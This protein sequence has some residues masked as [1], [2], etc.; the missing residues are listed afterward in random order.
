MKRGDSP[1]RFEAPP[2]RSELAGP[3]WS[4]LDPESGGFSLPGLNL[5]RSYLPLPVPWAGLF[6]MAIFFSHQLIDEFGE[7]QIY[8]S[9]SLARMVGL[10]RTIPEKESEK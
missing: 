4:T 2:I 7:P 5:S 10:D 3:P 9:L 1:R 6:G 8:G